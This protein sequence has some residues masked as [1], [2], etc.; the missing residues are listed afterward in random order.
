MTPWRRAGINGRTKKEIWV[1]AIV[2]P[3]TEKGRW[4]LP[5]FINQQ[6]AVQARQSHFSKNPI[7]M[8]GLEGLVGS[9]SSLF[10]SLHSLCCRPMKAREC[11]TSKTPPVGSHIRHCEQYPRQLAPWRTSSQSTE[12]EIFSLSSFHPRQ[13]KHSWSL[14]SISP[15]V[16]QGALLGRWA[17]QKTDPRYLLSF[18][19][20]VSATPA[21]GPGWKAHEPTGLQFKL[22]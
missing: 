14:L 13:V 2:N 6:S 4:W 18:S 15:L 10:C 20:V 21:P 1:W 9:L 16:T 17:R 11:L 8:Q 19:Q 22:L 5:Q 7:T 3:I 12:Q